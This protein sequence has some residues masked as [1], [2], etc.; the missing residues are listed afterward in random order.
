MAERDRFV[1]T[2]F[3]DGSEFANPLL[4][5]EFP[6]FWR[7]I[8]QVLLDPGPINLAQ[9]AD[10]GPVGILS[11]QLR[12]ASPDRSKTLNTAIASSWAAAPLGALIFREPLQRGLE[13]SA[14]DWTHCWQ[15]LGNRVN[16]LADIEQLP[17]SP[18]SQR[19]QGQSRGEEPK[20]GRE[21]LLLAAE[22]LLAT[23]LETS[24]TGRELATKAGV[25][26]G[27]VTHYFGSKNAA[28][29]EALTSLHRKFLDDVLA[30]G[31]AAMKGGARSVFAEHRAFLRAWASRLLRH[32]D[33]PEFELLGMQRLREQVFDARSITSRQRRRRL[34]AVGDAMTSVALQLGWTILRPL[35]SAVDR[36]ALVD[37]ENSLRS[38]H[39]RILEDP[40]A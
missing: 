21:Q 7:A 33:T 14:D 36:T 39:Q 37:I 13:I 32:A 17:D 19:G 34:D 22:E 24:V 31:A 26:Y 28:F 9:L 6:L 29:D 8:S 12:D 40:A 25:N 38:I 16:S 4:I 18:I 10:G 11:D 27:L 30:V 1:A 20:R 35:P 2:A 5:A 15:R 23:R 3:S